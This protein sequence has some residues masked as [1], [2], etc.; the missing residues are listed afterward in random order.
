VAN[1]LLIIFDECYEYFVFDGNAHLAA[2]VCQKARH[3]SIIVNTA[4]KTYAM[5]GWRIGYWWRPRKS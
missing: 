3:L 5:T 4:S 1:N 2:S